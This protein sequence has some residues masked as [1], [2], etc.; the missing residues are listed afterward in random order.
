L[1]AD[2]TTIAELV[3]GVD[4]GEPSDHL[5]LRQPLKGQEVEMPITGM[6]TPRHL[7][8]FCR[9]GHGM[10]H[11]NLQNVQTTGRMSYLRQKL[12]TIAVDA[13]ESPLDDNVTAVLIQL[14][15]TYYVNL[16]PR[17]VIH[18]S[19]APMFAFVA[20]E[21]YCASSFDL[22]NRTIAELDGAT[23]V[24]VKLHERSAHTTHVVSG[25]RVENP[26]MRLS[27]APLPDLG[28]HL[29]FLYLDRT[30]SRCGDYAQTQ[31][32]LSLDFLQVVAGHHRVYHG[33]SFIMRAY[34]E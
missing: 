3:D 2:E 21:E 29:R 11:P 32:L 15:K 30:G 16:E 19:K 26:P 25:S 4:E 1:L 22:G 33:I 20:E 18:P 24:E 10:L 8:C 27:A 7:F 14:A 34:Q 31:L 12:S 5:F 23:N 9:Q 13:H 6:P 28:V 17:Y